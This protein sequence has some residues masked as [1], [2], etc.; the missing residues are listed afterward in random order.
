MQF[1]DDGLD[2]RA[3][4]VELK[5]ADEFGKRLPEL[6][7]GK[8]AAESSEAGN[9][10][11]ADLIQEIAGP[12][13]PDLTIEKLAGVVDVMKPHLIEGYER[14]MRETDQIADAPTIEILEDI[15]RKNRRHVAWGQEVLDRL[16][17]T[18]A[19][20]QRRQARQRELHE[21][22]TK[23]GGVTGDLSRDH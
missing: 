9:Q 10:T 7:C 2:L 3:C 16:C 12:E 13:L 18:D 1:V 21:L 14:H 5:A 19:K 8:R 22:L 4:L 11:F 6:R 20:R 23:S 15:V 17:D